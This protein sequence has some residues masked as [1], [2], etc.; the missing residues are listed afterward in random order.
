[1]GEWREGSRRRGEREEGRKEGR[2]GRKGE[3]RKGK[4]KGVSREGGASTERRKERYNHHFEWNIKEATNNF[5][6][7]D[8]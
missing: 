6:Q 2:E 8:D 4:R 5:L 1:M 7:V 3:K